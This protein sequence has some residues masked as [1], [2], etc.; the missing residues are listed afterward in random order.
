ML[1]GN[2]P[3]KLKTTRSKW[4]CPKEGEQIEYKNPR[5]AKIAQSELYDL[6]KQGKICHVEYVENLEKEIEKRDAMIDK[7]VKLIE[8]ST[9]KED[10]DSLSDLKSTLKPS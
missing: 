9:I 2:D 4:S 6:F 1:M 7:L 5:F 8:K 3:T 10:K